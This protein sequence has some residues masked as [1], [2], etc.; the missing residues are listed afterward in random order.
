[1]SGILGFPEVAALASGD[2][3]ACVAKGVTSKISLANLQKQVG[4]SGGGSSSVG[5]TNLLTGPSDLT[6]QANWFQYDST[7]QSIA[8]E[9]PT[10]LNY[11][12]DGGGHVVYQAIP[13]ASGGKLVAG[14]TYTFGFNATRTAGGA[15]KVRANVYYEGAGSGPNAPDQTVTDGTAYR[16]AVTF[17]IPSGATNAHVGI[18]GT[19]GG[20]EFTFSALTLVAGGTDN[21]SAT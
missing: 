7:N 5:S 10:K 9:T 1:M 21:P 8:R 2:Y 12:T 14:Q 20:G 16:S 4:G 18:D 3:V 17:T 15:G 13:V 19:A 6:S 11:P